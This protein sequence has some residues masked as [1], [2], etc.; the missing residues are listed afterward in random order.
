MA[1]PS[2][3]RRLPLLHQVAS[4]LELLLNGE[5]QEHQRYQD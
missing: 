4:P 2:T 5:T 3:T 1:P